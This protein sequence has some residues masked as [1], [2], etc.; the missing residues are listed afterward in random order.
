MDLMTPALG[1]IFWQSIIFLISF[2]LLSS[3]AWKP[4]NNFIENREKLI[5]DSINDAKKKKNQIKEIK[6]KKNKIIKKTEI[7]KNLIINEAF[8]RKKK[9]EKEAKKKAILIC[10]SLIK[11]TNLLINNNKKMALEEFKKEILNNSIILSERILKQ[12]NNFFVKDL[13]QNIIS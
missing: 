7:I 3:F 1:L 8:K 5:L 12:K 11:K 4:I 10:D 2:I 9:I 6:N 13:I